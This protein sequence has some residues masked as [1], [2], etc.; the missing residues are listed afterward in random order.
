METDQPESSDTPTEPRY[1]PIDPEALRELIERYAT[2]PYAKE[3]KWEPFW[4]C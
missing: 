2:R 1:A 3:P 4:P